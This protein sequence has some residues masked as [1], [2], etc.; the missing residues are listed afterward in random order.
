MQSS[1]KDVHIKGKDQ[2]QFELKYLS[3]DKW[4]VKNIFKK[5]DGSNV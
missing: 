3:L 4:K 5:L 2:G 1:D